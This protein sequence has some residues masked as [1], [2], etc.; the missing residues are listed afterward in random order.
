RGSINNCYFNSGQTCS[1]HTRLLV[2]E[3]RHDEAVR[4]AKETAESFTVG[5]PREGRAKLGPLVS[6]IQ[7]ERVR[8]YIRKGIEEGAILATGASFAATGLKNTSKPNRCSCN[9][10]DPSI[11]AMPVAKVL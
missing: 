6:D 4:I 1:A 9:G 2:P 5:D 7:R 11:R 10:D 8:N 3:D